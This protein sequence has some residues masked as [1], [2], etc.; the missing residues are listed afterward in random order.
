V[1]DCTASKPAES[2]SS[3][4]V[5][6]ILF[7]MLIVFFLHCKA[8][9]VALTEFHQTVKRMSFKHQHSIKFIP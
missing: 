6:L 8:A 3:S 4:T 2:N 9:T 7:M 1:N 5:C